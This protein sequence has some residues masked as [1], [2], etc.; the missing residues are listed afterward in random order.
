M[1]HGRGVDLDLLA[2]YIGG[3]LDGTPEAAAV[4]RLIAD[5]P[6][7]S[8]AYAQTSAAMEAVRVDLGTLGADRDQMPA[9]VL[10]RLEAALTAVRRQ[11]SGT[12]V[13]LAPRRRWVR[14]LAPVA[15]AAGVLVLVGLGATALWPESGRQDVATNAGGGAADRAAVPDAAKLSGGGRAPLI[16][17]GEGTSQGLRKDAESDVAPPIVATGTNYRRETVRRLTSEVRTKALAAPQASTQMSGVPEPLRRLT[18]PAALSACLA[19]IKAADAQ[20]ATQV[21]LVDLARFEGSPAVVVL[22]PDVVWVSGANCGLTGPD[23][24]YSTR[25]EGS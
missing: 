21:R 14:R 6:A 24:R 15:A 23:T 9:E 4:E 16:A 12:V 20:P 1:T 11:E 2:D 22:L 7:W 3:A 18:D 25:T 17:P 5:D 13:P 8:R 10:G 19:A